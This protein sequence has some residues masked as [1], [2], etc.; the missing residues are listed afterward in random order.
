[1]F[2]SENSDSSVW[3][4]TSYSVNSIFKFAKF[5]QNINVKATWS[6]TL[7]LDIV[8]RNHLGDNKDLWKH[9]Y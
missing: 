2:T 6:I 4:P 5:F 3:L 8:A 7:S 1:M 9:L